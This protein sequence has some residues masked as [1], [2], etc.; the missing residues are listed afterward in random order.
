MR[1]LLFEHEPVTE[2]GAGEYEGRKSTFCRHCGKI[3][4]TTGFAPALEV[5]YPPHRIMQ[6]MRPVQ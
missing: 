6:T 1:C 5:N 2:E 3:F 4:S